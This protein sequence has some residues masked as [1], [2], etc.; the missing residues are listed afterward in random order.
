M[1][2]LLLLVSLIVLFLTIFGIQIDILEP[3]RRFTCSKCL[4]LLLM[5]AS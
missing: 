2:E 1:L 4:L 3:Y 5:L